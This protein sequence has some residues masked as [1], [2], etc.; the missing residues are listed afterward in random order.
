M[1]TLF[2]NHPRVRQ[3]LTVLLLAGALG[4]IFPPATPELQW[5]ARQS[6]FV[7]MGYVALGLF[8]LIGNNARLMFVCLGCGAAI[9][10]HYHEKTER[11]ARQK[12]SERPKVWEFPVHP[13][14]PVPGI[15]S[16]D[17]PSHE[18]ASPPR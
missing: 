11:I 9:S 5:W 8:F 1:K 4:C 17:P 12:I 7:A 15:I 13:P 3:I 2:F 16:T 6:F 18:P 14:G 10:F